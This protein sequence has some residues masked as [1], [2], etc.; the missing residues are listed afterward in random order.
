MQEVVAHGQ[1]DLLLNLVLVAEGFQEQEMGVFAQYAQRFTDKLF[2]TSPS[3]QHEVRTRVTLF[4]RSVAGLRGLITR[5]F[6]N[7]AMHNYMDKR[8]FSWA[9][10]AAP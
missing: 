6:G 3:S 2:S 1:Q 5:F 9:Y 4:Q 10:I 8:I 7:P